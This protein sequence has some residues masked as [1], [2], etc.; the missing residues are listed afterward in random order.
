MPTKHFVEDVEE[1]E[2]VDIE[3]SRSKEVA[4]CDNHKHIVEF[5][6]ESP[7]CSYTHYDHTA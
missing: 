4:L 7:Q 6:T 2:E 3:F 1:V 5:W